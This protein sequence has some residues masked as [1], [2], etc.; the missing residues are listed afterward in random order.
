MTR[1][2]W[3][4]CITW[5]FHKDSTFPSSSITSVRLFLFFQFFWVSQ[6]ATKKSFCIIF[7]SIGIAIDFVGVSKWHLQTYFAMALRE[8]CVCKVISCNNYKLC[9]IYCSKHVQMCSVML[10]GW[11]CAA[12]CKCTNYRSFSRLWGNLFCRLIVFDGKSLQ[13]RRIQYV[14]MFC[15]IKIAECH[16]SNNNFDGMPFSFISNWCTLWLRLWQHKQKCEISNQNSHS[17]RLRMKNEKE[18]RKLQA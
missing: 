15:R 11:L 7:K 14:A 9:I 6:S 5:T 4:C 13:L 10:N 16:L 1:I 2:L 18:K 12:M 3:S 8:Y 17:T